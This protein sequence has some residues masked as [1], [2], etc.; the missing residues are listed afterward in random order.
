MTGLLLLRYSVLL[1]MF[2]NDVLIGI[3]VGN[4]EIDSFGLE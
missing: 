4:M 3:T 2:S 1:V